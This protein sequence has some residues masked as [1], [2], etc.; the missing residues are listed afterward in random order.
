MS[1]REPREPERVPLGE[2]VDRRALAAQGGA[3]SR[4]RI[5]RA[6][7]PGWVLDADG[8]HARRDARVLFRESW[9]LLAGLIVFGAAALGLFLETFPRGWRGVARALLLLGVLLALGG[10]VAPRITRAIYRR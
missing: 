2:L 1:G 9:V 10:W 3:P 7:P 6:L 8:A 4:A 5:Q